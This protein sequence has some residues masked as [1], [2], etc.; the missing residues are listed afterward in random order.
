MLCLSL[1][2]IFE[3]D[4]RAGLPVGCIARMTVSALSGTRY[5]A[6]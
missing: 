4:V 3:Q 6:C 5:K 1:V 2:L